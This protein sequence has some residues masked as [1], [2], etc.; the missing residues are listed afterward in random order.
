MTMGR[1]LSL[2]KCQ[3][4]HICVS[5]PSNERDVPHGSIIIRERN[6]MNGLLGNPT[7]INRHI[8]FIWNE[9]IKNSKLKLN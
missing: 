1:V 9:S 7:C 3:S 4:V 5:S 6:I 8:I 2:G